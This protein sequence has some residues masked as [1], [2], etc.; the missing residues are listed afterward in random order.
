MFTIF[1]NIWG[2]ECNCTTFK[3]RLNTKAKVMFK[4]FIT[5]MTMNSSFEDFS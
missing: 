2:T 5:L 3:H 4:K 1:D